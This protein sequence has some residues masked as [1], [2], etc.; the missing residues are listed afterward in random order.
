MVVVGM[1]T[2]ALLSP[3][4]YAATPTP[5]RPGGA[6][7]ARLVSA[8]TLE[9]ELGGQWTADGAS[10]P[11][12]IKGS[13]GAVEPRLGLDLAG[14]DSGAW[15]LDAGA[16]VGIVQDRR[17]QLAGQAW[18]AV[19]TG[20]EEWAG[21]LGALLTV[22]TKS[23]LSLRTDAAIALAGGGGITAAGVPVAVAVGWGLSRRWTG[24]I[25][26][27]STFSGGG[28]ATAPT[29]TGGG[30][31]RPTDIVAGDVALGWDTEYGEPLAALG[32]TINAG[33]LRR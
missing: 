2:A 15:G 17:V 8:D 33:R 7:S 27:A 9:A 28:T 16:K 22:A 24:F 13:T 18:T 20:G 25:D 29:L 12:R 31:F 5:D 21:E 23:G 30:R 32:V 11:L 19:P 1:L 4:A 6:R 26:V 14:V 10:V 3:A